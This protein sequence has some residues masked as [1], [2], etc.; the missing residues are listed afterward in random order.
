MDAGPREKTETKEIGRESLN[1]ER[2]NGERR[3]PGRNA[4]MT[5]GV[6]RDSWTISVLGCGSLLIRSS[7]FQAH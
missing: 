3:T 7:S 4:R 2:K 5:P 1:P 6:I